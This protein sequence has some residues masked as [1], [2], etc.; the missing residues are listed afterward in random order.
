VAELESEAGDRSAD[1]AVHQSKTARYGLVVTIIFGVVTAALTAVGLKLTYD[2]N[3]Q[4][5]ES[6][7]KPPAAATAVAQPV[8]K[9]PDGKTALV[10]SP[11]KLSRIASDYDDNPVARLSTGDQVRI[12]LDGGGNDWVMVQSIIDPSLQG[13]VRRKFLKVLP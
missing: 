1:A 7:A 8:S 6:A 10:L 12:R 9:S 13:Y 4:D 3:V 5:A 11:T 2:K